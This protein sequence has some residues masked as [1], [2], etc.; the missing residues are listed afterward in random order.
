MNIIRS[1][2]VVRDTSVCQDMAPLQDP[3]VRTKQEILADPERKDCPLLEPCFSGQLQ[4]EG[5]RCA[6][7]DG[8]TMA[9]ELT[10]GSLD[11]KLAAEISELSASPIF[12]PD[13]KGYIDPYSEE[14]TKPELD[15]EK[16]IET[17]VG[18]ASLVL[19]G[20]KEALKLKTVPTSPVVGGGDAFSKLVVDDAYDI[21]YPDGIALKVPRNKCRC[22]ILRVGDFCPV[23]GG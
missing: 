17:V 20:D 2:E 7:L 12:K 16:A 13:G 10:G 21:V 15:K 1:T 19:F 5:V 4:R 11:R 18:Y 14:P 9:R 3:N 8:H 23:H 22:P 6:A